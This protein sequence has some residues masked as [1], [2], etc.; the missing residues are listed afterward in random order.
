MLLTPHQ[1]HIK[2]MTFTI[3]KQDDSFVLADSLRKE[4][5]D[6]NGYASTIIDSGLDHRMSEYIPNLKSQLNIL[7]DDSLS[8]IYKEASDELEYTEANLKRL[9]TSF[10]MNLLPV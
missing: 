7:L 3:G 10:H 1:T 8:N 5:V 9:I 6:I 2:S 4:Y